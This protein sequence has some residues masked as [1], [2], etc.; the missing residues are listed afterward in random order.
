[1][2][3]V[4][5]CY[6][7]DLPQMIIQAASMGLYLQNFHVTR[8]IV[9]IND[10]KYNE[11]ADYFEKNVRH[12]YGRFQNIVELIDASSLLDLSYG[13]TDQMKLK[14]LVSKLVNTDY[15]CILDSKNYL[16]HPWTLNDVYK[17]GKY[18]AKFL[19]ET[20]E[21]VVQSF[22]F[23]NINEIKHRIIENI[24]PYFASTEIC[25]F[26]I[27]MALEP[28]GKQPDHFVYLEFFLMQAAMIH[29]GK[30]IEDY[31]FEDI[32]WRCGIWM[33]NEK[34]FNSDNYIKNLCNIENN[35]KRKI[36][37]S[38][39]HREVFTVISNDLIEKQKLIWQTYNL[40]TYDESTRIINEIKKLN[41]CS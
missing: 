39:I 18:I 33:N 4:T 41:L 23:F 16:I 29:F 2:N 15:Y 9:I 26:L 5:V 20:D 8:I 30:T 1:M 11:C 37:V 24:T 25:K 6:S 27:P 17:N 34:Y 38:S 12:K 32:T 31:Y 3:F 19:K 7:K 14:I 40:A 28:W 36:L 21:S 35:K 22:K 10:L 13:Y